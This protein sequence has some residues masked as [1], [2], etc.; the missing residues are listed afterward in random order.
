MVQ[1]SGK[2]NLR[3]NLALRKSIRAVPWDQHPWG[4]ERKQDSAERE[5]MDYNVVTTNPMPTPWGVVKL[6]WPFRVV[7]NCGFEG[8]GHFT[9]STSN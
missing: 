4:K 9:I 5:K 8:L 1:V 2:Q 7:L 3:W 6:Q